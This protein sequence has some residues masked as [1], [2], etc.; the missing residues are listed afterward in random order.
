MKFSLTTG[1]KKIPPKIGLRL[2]PWLTIVVLFVLLWFSIGFMK[3]YFY[4][5]LTQAEEVSILRSQVSLRTINIKLYE[6]VI[7]ALENK[8]QTDPAKLINLTNPFTYD[9]ARPAE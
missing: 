1:L 8:K 2:L 4:D 3:I 7:M 5:T 6:Q 9:N